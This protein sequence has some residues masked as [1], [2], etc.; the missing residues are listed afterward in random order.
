LKGM[1]LAAGLGTRL[2]P[3][4]YELPKPAIPVLGR[5]VISYNMG[6]LSRYGVSELVINLH[7]VPGLLKGEIKKW[8]K[9]HGKIRYIIEPDILGT[10]GGIK[11]AQLSFQGEKEFIIANSD[12]IVDFDLASAIAYHHSR[13]AAVTMVLFPSLNEKYTS[14]FFAEGGEIISIGGKKEGYWKKGLYTG[15]SILSTSIFDILKKGKSCI[16]RDCIEPLIERDSSVYGYFTEGNFLDFGTPSGYLE[17][18]LSL[19]ETGEGGN[20]LD[21]AGAEVIPPVYVGEGARIGNHAT[22]GPLAVIERGSTIKD[23]ASVQRS[24]VWPNGVVGKGVKV[25][26]AIVTP[27]RILKCAP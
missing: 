6:F 15:V 4:T 7:R 18:T 3:L 20:I 1:I 11:N 24:I 17:S 2:R 14:V 5:P 23:G 12:T 13:G 16:I 22:I 8:G 19:L 10:G 26:N 25:S 27:Q 9:F 21:V